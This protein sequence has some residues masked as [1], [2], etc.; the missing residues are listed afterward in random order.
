MQNHVRSLLS[1]GSKSHSK[2]T[3]KYLAFFSSS[4]LVLSLLLM[5]SCGNKNENHGWGDGPAELPIAVVQQGE[6]IIPKE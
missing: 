1:G 3:N 4:G 6:A 2:S 5:G